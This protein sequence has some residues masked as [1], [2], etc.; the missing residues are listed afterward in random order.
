MKQMINCRIGVKP[1]IGVIASQ[2][3]V[4]V[5]VGGISRVDQ[6]VVG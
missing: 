1:S 4:V 5:V 6:R 3:V 2:L